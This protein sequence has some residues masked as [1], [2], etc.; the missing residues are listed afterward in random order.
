[1]IEENGSLAGDEDMSD[2]TSRSDAV[3]IRF[4]TILFATDFSPASAKAVPYVAAVVRRFGS[5]LCVAHV[6]P[7]RAYAHIPPAQRPEAL[8][9][10]RADA[11]S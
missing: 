10:M 1:V 4:A 9:R 8:E 7:P 3:S 5:K 6:I 11:E 2:K